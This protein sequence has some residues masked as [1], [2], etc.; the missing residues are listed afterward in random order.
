[1]HKCRHLV[2][3][4]L[5]AIFICQCFTLK[6]M[7]VTIVGK[8]WNNLLHKDGMVANKVP[9]ANSWCDNVK[10]TYRLLLCAWK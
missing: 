6:I 9:T 5:E 7:C 1:M 10:S 3:L 8:W 2:I 4:S